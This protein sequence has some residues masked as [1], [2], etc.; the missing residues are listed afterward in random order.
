MENSENK[1]SRKNDENELSQKEM[2]LST[3]GTERIRLFPLIILIILI[4]IRFLYPIL[5]MK[6]IEYGDDDY[7]FHTIA[8]RIYETGNVIDNFSFY[9]MDILISL[10]AAGLY[11]IFGVNHFYVILF[12]SIFSLISLFLLFGIVRAISVDRRIYLPALFLVVLYPI[13]YLKIQRRIFSENLYIPLLITIVWL[14]IS[15]VESEWAG[16]RRKELVNFLLI[17]VASSLLFWARQTALI[18]WAAFMIYY[19]FFSPRRIRE[20]VI[21]LSIYLFFSFLLISPMFWLTYKKFGHPTLFVKS[22]GV[23]LYLGNN[24]EATGELYYPKRDYFGEYISSRYNSKKQ[25]ISVEQRETLLKEYVLCYIKEDPL[26]W[27]CQ[28]FAKLRMAVLTTSKIPLFSLIIFLLA[29]IG[30][31]SPRLN[32]G[33]YLLSLVILFHMVPIVIFFYNSRYRAVYEPFLA[34]M[35]AAGLITVWDFCKKK[36]SVVEVNSLHNFNKFSQL[37]KKC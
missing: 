33:K 15:L 5:S 22:S 8:V 20:K 9:Y 26:R 7:T 21:L 6:N 19:S 36:K 32:S 14:G 35:A 1:P 2:K 31:L 34:V 13:R 10:F 24:P 25:D 27:L 30:L 18:V 12:N 17:I 29:M 28:T 3:K 23:N 16:K 37:Q 4:S 11:K